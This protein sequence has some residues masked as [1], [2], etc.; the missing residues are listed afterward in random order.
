M[1]E[2]NKTELR[3]LQALPLD[4][5]TAKSKQRIREAI[6]YFG[7]SGLYVPISGGNDSMVLSHLVREVQREMKIPHAAIPRVNANTGNEY[8][9][10]LKKA[11][12]MS[13]IEVKPKKNLVQVLTEEGYPIGSKKVSR[14][15]RD[16][17]NPT[18]NNAASRKLYIEGIKR[19]GTKTKSF[20]MP[21]MW[22]KF[23]NSDLR[24]SEKCCYWLK[25]EPMHRYEKETGRHPFLGTMA[26]EG[27]TREGGYM[28]TGCN[29]FKAGK[30]MPLGFWT[31]ND[32]LAYIILH[33]L[34]MAS[35]YGEI[36]DPRNKKTPSALKIRL[37]VKHGRRIELDT[38]LEKR[39][40]CVWCMLGVQMEKGENRFQRLARLD[41]RKYKFAIEGGT[42]DN[43]GK[44][45]PKSGLGIGKELDDL[46]IDYKPLGGQIEGQMSIDDWIL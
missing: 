28:Q 40:G 42:Y 23:I 27:G 3:M 21:L 29:A 41:P 12:E 46:G 14:M 22:R 32:T 4:I 44:W 9:E 20:K 36:I 39:T 15:L 25:K 31:K 13:K 35:V 11:R 7:V 5:K 34:E 8:D 1:I 33:G 30:S 16:L 24:V 10:V 18:E 6:Y 19:D 45:I 37:M 43:E 2:L 26:D 38:T 17:Q